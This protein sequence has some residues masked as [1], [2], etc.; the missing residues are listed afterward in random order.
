[1]ATAT[2]ERLS[3]LTGELVQVEQ[4]R[5][6][7]IDQIKD[8]V[9]ALNQDS[10]NGSQRTQE[11]MQPARP[12]RKGKKSAIGTNV[13][14]YAAVLEILGNSNKP[15]SVEDL[16]SQLQSR[17]VPGDLAALRMTLR[18][19]KRLGKVKQTEDGLLAAAAT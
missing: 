14:R 7:I 13:G 4:K 5:K 2:V 6:S 12:P 15:M 8:Q 9:N 3:R 10:N 17:K 18:R 19:G 11:R 1:M 16:Q